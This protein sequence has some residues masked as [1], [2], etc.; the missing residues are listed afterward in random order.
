MTTSV[1]APAWCDSVRA[2]AVTVLYHIHYINADVCRHFLIDS[3]GIFLSLRRTISYP[4]TLSAYN[5]FLSIS[6]PS[7]ST[8]DYIPYLFDP[9]LTTFPTKGANTQYAIPPT[10]STESVTITT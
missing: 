9:I 5:I 8:L 6:Y 4:R 10:I 1:R 7:V 2:C 3:Y